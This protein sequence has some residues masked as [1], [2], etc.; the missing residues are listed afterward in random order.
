MLLMYFSHA[1]FT[2]KTITSKF[3]N[4]PKRVVLDVL[5]VGL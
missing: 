5:I 1:S 2:G 3:L 4:F